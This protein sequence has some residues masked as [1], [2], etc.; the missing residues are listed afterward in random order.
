MQ[1][2]F[3]I[4][5]ARSSLFYMKNVTSTYRQPRISAWRSVSE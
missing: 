3:H 1:I 5:T 2:L 4:E